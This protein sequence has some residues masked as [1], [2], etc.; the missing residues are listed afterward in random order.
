MD[1]QTTTNATHEAVH[2]STGHVRFS[3]SLARRRRQER[4]ERF[5][6]TLDHTCD[7]AGRPTVV[8]AK[9]PELFSS[10][11]IRH[12]PDSAQRK[13]IGFINAVAAREGNTAPDVENGISAEMYL[14]FQD[15]VDTTVMAGFVEPRV[16]PTPEEADAAGGVW[17]LDI[18]MRDRQ[19]FYELVGGDVNAAQGD[20]AT[21]RGGPA[22]PVGTGPTEPAVPNEVPVSGNDVT[23]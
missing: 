8:I 9:R 7:D 15:V 18:D 23:Y 17:I 4:L 22:T 11:T 12:L 16:Y 14:M 3:N 1:T 2:G 10:D 20:V 21:F 6:F 19:R 5:E 13:V